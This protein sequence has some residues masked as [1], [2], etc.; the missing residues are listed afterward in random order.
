MPAAVIEPENL[1]RMMVAFLARLGRDHHGS[2]CPVIEFKA[3]VPSRCVTEAAGRGDLIGI[4]DRLN[5]CDH[6]NSCLARAKCR[7]AI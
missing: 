1:S 4:S 6:V 3:A 5:F 7:P 2:T